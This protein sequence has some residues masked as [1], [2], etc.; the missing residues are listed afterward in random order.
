M[1]I[2][3]KALS[4]YVLTF[5]IWIISIVVCYTLSFYFR[6][7]ATLLFGIIVIAT[8]SFFAYLDRIQKQHEKELSLRLREIMLKVIRFNK[9]S[10]KD[11]GLKLR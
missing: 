11:I 9:E 10:L 3:K 2:W 4:C 8:L 5:I 7:Q 1:P 6:K